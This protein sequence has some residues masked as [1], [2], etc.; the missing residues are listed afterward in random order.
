M[1]VTG[2]FEQIRFNIY[3]PFTCHPR[4]YIEINDD[5]GT[6]LIY[7]ILSELSITVLDINY[8]DGIKKL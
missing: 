8:V 3:E 1:L 2:M 6:L 7:I 4:E 5:F